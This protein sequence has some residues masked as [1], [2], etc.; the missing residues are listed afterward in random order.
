MVDGERLLRSCIAVIAT[1]VAIASAVAAGRAVDTAFPSF[2]VD[3]YGDFSNVYLDS[4]GTQRAGFALGDRVVAVEGAALGDGS[5]L[6][7]D[8]LDR[9]VAARS[10]AGF[11][12]VAVSLSRGGSLR[13]STVAIRHLGA[14]EVWWFW[15]LYVSV[16]VGVL[17][18]GLVAHR[19]AGRRRGANAH[20]LLSLS[21]FVFLA[22]F[23][24]YHTTKWLAPLFAASTLGN[25]MGLL[26][27][28]L[29][30]PSP[31]SVR[32]GLLVAAKIAAI[33]AC[34]GM[35]ALAMDPFLRWDLRVLRSLVT[36]ITPLPLLALGGLTLVRLR[37]AAGQ[38][39]EEL[40]SSAWGVAGAPVLIAVA[41]V[42]MLATGGATFHIALPFGVLAFPLAVAYA[43][44]RHN[45][46]RTKHLIRRSLFLAPVLAAA[47]CVGG[48]VWA[49]AQTGPGLELL[50]VLTGLLAGVMTMAGLSVL[51]ERS[52]FLSGS[53]FR[54]SIEKLADR[55]ATMRDPEMIRASLIQVVSELLH[56][57]SVELREEPA[58]P[59]AEPARAS[60]QRS[61]DMISAPLRTGGTE[62]GVLVVSGRASGAPFS[63]EDVQLLETIA[64]LCAIALRN[65]R[66]LAELEE[67][68][69]LERTAGSEKE[70]V[71]MDLLG[72]ELA[73]EVAYPLNYFRHL[74]DRLGGGRGYDDTDVEIG[75][76]EV[77]RLNR[78][79]GS[80]RSLQV[81]SHDVARLRIASVA[82][83]AVALLRGQTEDKDLV[84]ET[85]IDEGLTVVANFDR[86]LQLL[87][88]L[89]R[90]AVQA[91]RHGGRVVIGAKRH[92][93][94]ITIEV[95]DDGDGVPGALAPRIFR[96][97]VSGR[98]GGTGLGLAV[99]QRIARSFDWTLEHQ[100][101][102]GWTIF[103]V[104][105]PAADGEPS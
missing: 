85:E 30:F 67:L 90:N 37:S 26:A 102:G 40:M 60:H 9:A 84:I 5:V 33:A 77:A 89:L 38:E 20:L 69:E 82:E 3:P 28:A 97:F 95:R 62:F 13:A 101:E 16:G 17:W 78:M 12:S 66:S 105:A 48:S 94:E 86:T 22:T 41:Y 34:G 55:L 32:R 58:A 6:L 31:F 24:D 45:I 71:T 11:D 50:P 29:N 73:H 23:F 93:R 88:N 65:A 47:V 15:G 68:R 8:Q 44:M 75:R 53:R 18:S 25:A 76:E 1:V 4:W 2:F 100:R 35:L 52:A 80:L 63:D 39:R 104:R 54:P 10:R 27:V 57:D 72:A 103:R 91:A 81:P 79:L 59:G 70:R 14:A 83:R 87:S 36:A 74:L 64:S 19:I 51:V 96:P 7:A 43:L 61:S 99:A 49:I 21:A 42:A 92:G 98:A 46:W 56:A